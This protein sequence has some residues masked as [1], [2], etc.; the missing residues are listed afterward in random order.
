MFAVICTRKYKSVNTLTS[1]RL[2]NGLE[3]EYKKK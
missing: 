1:L 3:E 2:G